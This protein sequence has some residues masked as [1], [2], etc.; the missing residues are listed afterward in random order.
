VK[1]IAVVADE[2]QMHQ[3]WEV[4]YNNW[5]QP[6]A[7][8]QLL[9]IFHQGKILSPASRSLLTGYMTQTPTGPRRIKGMLPG[10]AVVFHKTGSSGTNPKGITAAT[11]DAGIV[12][13]PSGKKYAIVV[14]VS[15]ST[16]DEALREGVIARIS[17]L[18]WDYFSGRQ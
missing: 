6:A 15:D 12:T 18:S 13:L 17:K 2:H 3:S 5:C 14:F 11:N 1:G 9:D 7:M 10:S 8:A 4:Q 16:A